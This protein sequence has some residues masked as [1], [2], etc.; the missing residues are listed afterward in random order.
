M[1][2]D[3]FDPYR[4]PTLPEGPFGPAPPRS[5]RPGLL[6]TLCV[7]CIVLGALGLMNSLLGVVGVAGGRA[8]QAA[9]QPKGAAGLPADMQEAQ[10]KFNQDMVAVQDKFFWAIVPGL[11]IRFVAALLLL[12]GGIKA[13]SLKE[14]GRKLLLVACAVA[15]VF[16]ISHSILQSFVNLETM[17][18]VNSYVTSLPRQ[19]NAPPGMEGT[20]QTIVRA[21]I[22]GS[23][24]FAYLIALVKIALYV[25][26]LIYLR[27][28]SIKQLFQPHHEPPMIASIS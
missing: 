17:T 8:I 27:R 20:I 12:I 9:F 25:F 15:V 13:L 18:A 10:D 16:E 5:G 1:T 28:D 2:A 6:T 26:G 11:G 4:S 23:L 22:I 19:A 14:S 21:S 24:I 7:L 3:A